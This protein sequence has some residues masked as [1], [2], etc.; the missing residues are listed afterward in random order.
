MPTHARAAADA[1]SVFA[2]F[3]PF[4]IERCAARSEGTDIL[5][6]GVVIASSTNGWTI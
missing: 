5:E 1:C 3:T 4:V 6:H 2:P